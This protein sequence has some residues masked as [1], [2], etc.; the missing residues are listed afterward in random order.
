MP[1]GVET[2]W[3]NIWT[4]IDGVFIPWWIVVHYRVHIETDRKSGPEDR[5]PVQFPMAWLVLTDYR[6]YFRLLYHRSLDGENDQ[7]TL[8]APSA[9]LLEVHPLM[10]CVRSP[11]FIINYTIVEVQYTQILMVFF[12][13]RWNDDSGLALQTASYT[14]V[15][16][17]LRLLHQVQPYSALETNKCGIRTIIIPRVHRKPVI[18]IYLSIYIIW[19]PGP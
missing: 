19:S 8:V 15:Q 9:T 13:I 5:V 2:G 10:S 14:R 4:R 6:F 12:L 16:L 7:I 1:S 17:Q 11:A 3:E 18:Y